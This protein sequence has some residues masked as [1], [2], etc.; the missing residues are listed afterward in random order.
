MTD[1]VEP[2]YSQI[3]VAC[4]AYDENY[5]PGDGGMDRDAMRLALMAAQKV[6]PSCYGFMRFGFSCDGVNLQTD[7]VA[8]RDKVVRWHHDSTTAIPYHEK[9]TI[10]EL[11]ALRAEVVQL[12]EALSKTWIHQP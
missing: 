6:D 7:S 9:H 12:R 4:K 8:S 2:T 5:T 10:P 3:S 11:R 1:I